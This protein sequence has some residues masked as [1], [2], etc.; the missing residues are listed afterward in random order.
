MSAS[1]PAPAA[2]SDAAGAGH[3]DLFRRREV[4]RKGWPSA[5]FSGKRGSCA[6]RD[7]GAVTLR[8]VVL[9]QAA[10]TLAAV[11]L[12]TGCI[13]RSGSSAGSHPGPSAS[14]PADQAQAMR[15]VATC[16]R[17]H[18]Y[19]TFPDPIQYPDGHWGFPD[20]APRTR[21]TP[22]DTLGRQAK[23]LGRPRD[24]DHRFSA[25]DMVKLRQFSVC[26]RQ[27]GVADWPDPSARGS[28]SLPPRLNGLSGDTLLQPANTACQK[29]LKGVNIVI[30][31]GT[32]RKQ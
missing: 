32:G 26:M 12:V 21:A 17:S 13:A 4:T 9:A 28:F 29:L 11:A 27:H 30:D 6:E 16:L 3:R 23:S 18:G 10:V 1:I 2:R 14:A 22:C 19:P 7:C 24:K 20:S 25:A 15:A 5:H 31:T 8:T